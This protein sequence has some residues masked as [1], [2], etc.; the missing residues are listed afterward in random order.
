MYQF[1][2]YRDIDFYSLPK[3]STKGK[4]LCDQFLI[5]SGL[6]SKFPSWN[7]SAC[8]SYS[9][10]STEESIKLLNTDAEGCLVSHVYPRFRTLTNKWEEF[11]KQEEEDNI[12]TI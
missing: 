11:S 9:C 10:L 12:N 5:D 1:L 3:K 7:V 6:K 8:T 4:E 2:F